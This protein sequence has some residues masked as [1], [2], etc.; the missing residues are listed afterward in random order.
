MKIFSVQQGTTEWLALRAGIPT[1]SQFDRIITPQGKASGQVE[2]Y[3]FALLAERMMGHPIIEQISAWMQRGNE[4]E[5]EAVDFYESQRELETEPIGFITNDEGTIGA[6]PDR[7]VGEDGLLEI[8]VPAEHTH[9][10]YLL[11]KAV[12]QAYYPQVQG[13]L[14][15]SGRKWLDILSYHPEMPPA[16]IRVERDEA[17]IALLIEAVG[18]FSVLLEEYAADL[19]KRGWIKEKPQAVPAAPENSPGSPT[20][21]TGSFAG[22][23]LAFLDRTEAPPVATVA[24]SDNAYKTFLLLAAW[25]KFYDRSPDH[26]YYYKVLLANGV[27]HANEIRDLR[28]GRKLVSQLVSMILRVNMV[29]FGELT[30][31]AQRGE[32]PPA[33]SGPGPTAG[34]TQTGSVPG[35][36]EIA[37]PASNLPPASKVPAPQEQDSGTVPRASAVSETVEAPAG[38]LFKP[39]IDQQFEDWKRDLQRL[40][41]GAPRQF[42]LKLADWSFTSL[43]D[44]IA[45]LPARERQGRLEAMRLWCR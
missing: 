5:A 41:G 23:D 13:Q 22:P 32:R 30:A 26:H 16:L 8:K 14:W 15:I 11:K 6:S 20:I 19:K 1:A 37:P 34:S 7:L 4:M 29:S 40:F 42:T 39:A 31:K 44:M 25:L 27:H 17:F 38:E 33:S 21:E 24:R 2:K 3:L 10:S 9:V 12:D 35:A 18:H 36:T 28:T 45:N 43:D